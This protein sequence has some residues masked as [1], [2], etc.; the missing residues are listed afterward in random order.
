MARDTLHIAL[1]AAV[2]KTASFAP[3]A[4]DYNLDRFNELVITLNITAAER[5]TTQTYDFYV[6]TGDGS[7]EWDLVHFPQIAVAGATK[8]TA[9]VLSSLLPQTVTPAA[10]G[11]A[12]IAPGIINTLTTNA[13]KTLG[14]GQVAH[15]PWGNYLR[16]EL[17][18]AGTI[19]TGISY[20]VQVEA[21][22]GTGRAVSNAVQSSGG[23]GSVN[24]DFTS[25]LL[26]PEI[27]FT[28]SSTGTYF[29]NAGVLITASANAARFN[30]VSGVACLLVEPA[31][32]N[33][34][35]NSNAF[36]RN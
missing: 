20:T 16:Y 12:A 32:T 15:G 14:A 9:R 26:P 3:P 27:T 8:L 24:F 21:A 10:P 4:R 30:Y 11:V 25:G 23:G 29:N 22:W 13:P 17:V 5:T 31:A 33:I 1:D 19:T 18:C 6:I 7:S 34:L 2:T 35:P 36:L 28:R